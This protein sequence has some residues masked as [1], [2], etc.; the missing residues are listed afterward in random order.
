MKKKIRIAVL[1]FKDFSF[2]I[3]YQSG[4]KTSWFCK[5]KNYVVIDFLT[6]ANRD[7]EFNVLKSYEIFICPTYWKFF[8]T[9]F[10][11]PRSE[12]IYRMSFVTVST[13]I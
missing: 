5:N 6:V 7:M 4:E 3:K 9:F 2:S 11:I 1:F 13:Y 10:K 8:R 12:L